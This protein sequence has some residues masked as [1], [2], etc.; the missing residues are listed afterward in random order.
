MHKFWHVYVLGLDY[1]RMTLVTAQ[2]PHIT[3]HFVKSHRG[4]GGGVR[5]KWTLFIVV[6]VDVACRQCTECWVLPW[7]YNLHCCRAAKY[8]ALLLTTICVQYYEF[9]SLLFGMK[10]VSCYCNSKL[11]KTSTWSGT[12]ILKDGRFTFIFKVLI[13]TLKQLKHLH[14]QVLAYEEGTECFETSTYKIQTPWNYPEG[15]I[16]H[17]EYGDS[18]KSRSSNM[19]RCNHHHQGTHYLSLL[20][21]YLLKQSIKIVV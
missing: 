2:A 13:F 18:L 15:N 4:C 19:F 9:V 21:L 5:K 10:N 11:P 7:K 8:L 1:F 12:F 16:Q 3:A 17:T 20:Q 14:R 6:G